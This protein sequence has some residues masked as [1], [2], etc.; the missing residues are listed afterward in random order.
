VCADAVRAADVYLAVMGFRYGPPVAD[1][2]ELAVRLLRAAVPDDPW[3]NPPAWPAW[4]QLLPHVLVA[5]DPH[6]TITDAEEEVAWLLHRAAT[7]MQSR[8]ELDRC[9]NAP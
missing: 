6:R 5:T 3:D 8:G 7:Y 2:P 4:R 1:H 9:L